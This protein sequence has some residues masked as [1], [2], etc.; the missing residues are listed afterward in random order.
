MRLKLRDLLALSTVAY[1]LSVSSK[2]LSPGFY[3]DITALYYRAVLPTSNGIPYHAYF[4]EYPAIPAILI[5]VSGLAPSFFYYM[6]TMAFLMFFFV[7]AAVYFLYR[8]CTEFG[9]DRGRIIPFFI[10]APS[11]LVMSF[12]N[13]DIIAVCFVIAAIYYLF[14]KNSRL[15]GLCLGLGFAAKAYPLLLLPPFMK[16]VGSW[17]DRFEML[18]STVLG[19]LIPNLPFI[20]IDFQAWLNSNLSARQAVYIEES[21]W[22]V[23]R[24][25]RL[26]NQDWLI[27]AVAWSL[28]ILSIL[29]MTF[30]SKP[31]V[32]KV[33]VITAVTILVYPSYPPQY[34]LWLLPM[35]VLNP[36]FALIP[37]LAFDFLNTSIILSWFTVDNPFQPWGPIWDIS[38]IRI[39][40]L[41]LLL[42][43]AT[44]RRHASPQRSVMDVETGVRA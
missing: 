30:S 3:T 13:W 34:N 15:S 7:I 35:F 29:H 33:W 40:L 8:I 20:I 18:L 4:L 26:V 21:I 1:L 42:I 27:T 36:I 44:H 31:L 41:A 2:I 38:L 43:W 11:F 10:M 25:Y 16:E 6:V 5:W 28:I 14:R 9:M 12:F 23:T 32:L 19:A 24:Y 22:V 37:F 17:R 39:G